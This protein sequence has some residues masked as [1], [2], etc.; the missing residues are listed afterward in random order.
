MKPGM[1]TQGRFLSRVS[2][3]A[4]FVPAIYVLR[5]AHAKKTW[6]PGIK[7]GMTT[8]A[9]CAL[10]RQQPALRFAINPDSHFTAKHH[11]PYF[12]RRRVRR[13][14]FCSLKKAREM[15]RQVAQPLFV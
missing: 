2:V 13:R 5:T 3:M 7:R 11:R 9:D 1:T 4:G 6:M 8:Q 15:A 14:H 10:R 12:F